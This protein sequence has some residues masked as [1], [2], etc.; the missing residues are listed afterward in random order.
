MPVGATSTYVLQHAGQPHSRLGL[1]YRY[2][3]R[4]SSGGTTKVTLSFSSGGRLRR[5][6]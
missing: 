4:T 1:D 3:G 5:I 2:C 6:T